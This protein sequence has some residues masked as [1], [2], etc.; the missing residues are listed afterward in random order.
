MLKQI[1]LVFPLLFLLACMQQKDKSI[2]LAESFTPSFTTFPVK[3][4]IRAIEVVDENTVWFAGSGGKYGFTKNAGESWEVDSI[5]IEEHILEFRA[6]AITDKA[7]FLLNV[8]SP[9]YLLKSVDQGQHWDIV[10]Q[11]NH[12]DC[13]YNSMKFWDNKNGIAVG[14]ARS[15]IQLVI[16]KGQIVN[17]RAAAAD[18]QVLNHYRVGVC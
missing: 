15:E 4:S 6:I 10:Y 7:L 14:V 1:I 12:P 8:P 13:F 9:A 11:E 18:S 16:Q 3:S 17:A 2:N 5:Q